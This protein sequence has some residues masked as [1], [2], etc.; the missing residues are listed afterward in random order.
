MYEVIFILLK[1]VHYLK[2]STV[3]VVLIGE[4]TWK[5]KHVDWEIG[6]SLRQTQN[7]SRS[8]LLGI[9]LPTYPRESVKKYNP[10]TIPP[11]LMII[12]ILVL[13]KSIIGQPT[14]I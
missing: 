13:L 9:I 4:E 7:N 14:L 8:G 6:S 1:W 3:T 2:D 10:Y 5:R 11:R 12:L